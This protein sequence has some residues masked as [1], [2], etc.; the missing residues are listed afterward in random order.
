MKYLFK[1]GSYSQ[2]V[3]IFKEKKQNYFNNTLYLFNEPV[4]NE[5]KAQYSH[6]ELPHNVKI[7]AIFQSL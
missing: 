2:V 5:K 4:Q 1:G 6:Y 3:H 7:L